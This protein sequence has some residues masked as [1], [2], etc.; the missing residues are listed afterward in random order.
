MGR[1]GPSRTRTTFESPPAAVSTALAASATHLA[2]VAR[3]EANAAALF[4]PASR[5]PCPMRTGTKTKLEKSTSSVVGCF[6]PARR[7]WSDDARI[8]FFVRAADSLSH[9]TFSPATGTGTPGPSDGSAAMS[10][11]PNLC[12][13]RATSLRKRRAWRSSGCCC[14][15]CRQA[16]T[17][18]RT[19]CSG[20]FLSTS[21]LLVLPSGGYSAV[22]A[23]QASG[24]SIPVPRDGV[25]LSTKN[26]AA[27]NACSSVSCAWGSIFV[28]MSSAAAHTERKVSS[29]RM[30][31][32]NERIDDEEEEEEEYALAEGTG[33]GLSL[34]D[35]A[36]DFYGDGEYEFEEEELVGGGDDAWDE[37]N[38][39]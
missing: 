30:G 19:A 39:A 7:A 3:T 36:D 8:A 32:G 16:T 35:V 14:C 27:C 10:S 15:S 22:S 34:G 26:R 23:V 28:S 1:S 31:E 20:G 33:V 38:W 13:S 2:H 24:T 12:A 6:L 17:A 5:S 9:T 29:S 25:A 37:A 18:R 21:M 11:T 4:A